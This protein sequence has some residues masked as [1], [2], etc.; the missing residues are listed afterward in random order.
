MNTLT[1]L[2]KD[3]NVGIWCKRAAWIVVTFGLINI[4]LSVYGSLSLSSSAGLISQAS[5]LMQALLSALSLAP[6]LLFSFFILYAAGVLVDHV[7][8]SGEE[9]E[10]EGEEEEEEEEDKEAIPEQA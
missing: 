5:I 4:G 10:I 3:R 8:T 9:N 6:S 2:L 7:V 1:N